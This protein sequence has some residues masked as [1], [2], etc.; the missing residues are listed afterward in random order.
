MIFKFMVENNPKC[1]MTEDKCD[2]TCM[3]CEQLNEKIHEK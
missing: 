3:Y 2:K 1:R